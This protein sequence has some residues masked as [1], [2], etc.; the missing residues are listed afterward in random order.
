MSS[1]LKPPDQLD[2]HQST[3]VDHLDNLRYF[4]RSPHPYL[5]HGVGT[6]QDRNA[7]DHESDTGSG[8]VS[9]EG[10][11]H[12]SQAEDQQSWRRN[13]NHSSTTAS[14]SGT[15]ADDE[16]PRFIKAL[17][18]ASLRSSKGLIGGEKHDEDGLTPLL[19]P[20]QLDD[21]GRRLS[22]DYFDRKTSEEEAKAAQDKIRRRRL[23][24]LLR[25]TSEAGL[26]AAIAACVLCGKDSVTV[27]CQWQIPILGFVMTIGTLVLSYPIKLSFLERSTRFTSPW[28][29]FRVPASFDPATVLYPTLLP[30]LIALVLGRTNVEAVLPN[31]I[32]GLASLPQ[33]LFPRTSRVAG[34]NS[35]HWLAANIPLLLAQSASGLSEG[36]VEAS[37]ASRPNQL[38]ETLAVLYPLH[39][40]LLQPLYY[41][42]TTSL[43]ISELHL[44]AAGLINILLHAQ[45]PQTQVLK[46]CLWIGGVTL[47]VLTFRILHWNV[48]LARIPKWKLRRPGHPNQE[49]KS[50]V[51][52]VKQ[53]INL[54]KSVGAF[55]S[56]TDDNTSDADEDEPSVS[57]KE[58]IRHRPS[59]STSGIGFPLS[60]S[61][62]VEPRSAIERSHTFMNGFIYDSNR[63][64]S[65]LRRNTV[66]EGQSPEALEKIRHAKSYR[67]WSSNLLWCLQLTPSEAQQRKWLY[68]GYVYFT[69]LVIVMLPVRLYVQEHAFQGQEPIGWALGYLLSEVDLFTDVINVMKLET[70]IALPP[71]HS[72]L[73]IP[74]R[75]SSV[76][77]FD[78]LRWTVGPANTRLLIVAYWVGVLIVGL[79]TVFSLTAFVEVDTRRKVFHGVMV[80]MLVPATF[81]DPC[82]CA[83]ALALALAVFLLLEVIRAGQVQPIGNA[84]SKF[85]APYVDG[86]DLRGPV[87]VSHIF[88]LIG[89]AIPMWFSLSGTDRASPDHAKSAWPGWD[90]ADNK[91]DVGM[92]AGVICVG[93]GD[94]AAS[95]I[96]R[97][98][99]RRKWIWI[100]GKSLEGSAAFVV[101]V[102]VG[103]MAAKAWLWCGGWRDASLPDAARPGDWSTEAFMLYWG[104]SIAKATLCACGASFMEAVLTGANDNVVVPVALWLLVKGIG[105]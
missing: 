86:R 92:V 56:G 57:L 21:E 47:F 64:I 51:D 42:T 89:C 46:A 95:L 5:R 45:T 19:T 22:Q 94:S 20:S 40:S 100:G 97:R 38:A 37:N 71:Q 3:S 104:V 26:M 91:R 33:R 16:R 11:R 82:F 84:I 39:H 105:V 30:I 8:N 74:L 66:S 65:R 60:L 88:L 70:W 36:L 87:V 2:E 63:P 17:P 48:T 14:E 98:F 103:L 27:A 32:L 43:L 61:R 15:E 75:L 83:L 85:V 93:M 35:V 96:G 72:Y 78:D 10:R 41:L 1:A 29:R 31:L 67:G 13:S 25:R 23:A 90:L 52:A 73:H 53:L 34:F 12:Q 49:R 69:L 28:Q 77:H 99:G 79:L 101:A 24:E 76:R 44:L 68:A 80:A 6:Q 4:S 102:T 54:Q 50:F 55:S 9:D 81:V 62:S 18:P 58:R 7:G 59:L